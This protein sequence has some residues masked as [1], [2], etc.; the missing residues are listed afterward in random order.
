MSTKAKRH[1]H[2]YRRVEISG[3]KVWACAI[4]DCP[5]YM[6]R[7]LETMVLGKFSYC[8]ECNKQITLDDVSMRDDNPLCYD[9][10]H[11]IKNEPKVEIPSNVDF[12][13]LAEFL[14]K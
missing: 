11:G 2:K 13:Q 4:G 10:K 7:H 6:P 9:C 14:K 8:W 3:F 12:D 1:I 5:H